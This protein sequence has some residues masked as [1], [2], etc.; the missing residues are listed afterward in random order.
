MQNTKLIL[1]YF[2][3]LSVAC[4]ICRLFEEQNNSNTFFFCSFSIAI[5]MLATDEMAEDSTHSCDAMHTKR[6]KNECCLFRI[7]FVWKW[8]DSVEIEVNGFG[9][10]RCYK[11]SIEMWEENMTDGEHKRK[12]GTEKRKAKSPASKQNRWKCKESDICDIMWWYLLPNHLSSRLT[13]IPI[14]YK[15]KMQEQKTNW[16]RESDGDTVESLLTSHLPHDK[17][18]LGVWC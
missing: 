16:C 15:S 5:D 8:I 17:F 18:S 14:T 10:S 9:K 2:C 13:L 3:V 11:R 6:K 1:T 4:K 7:E 12:Q